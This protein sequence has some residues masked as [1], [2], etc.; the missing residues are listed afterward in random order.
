MASVAVAQTIRRL[1]GLPAELKWPN[2]VLIGGRKVCGILAEMEAEMDEVDFV[3]LGIGINV[4]C[5]I[6]Q[7]RA[8]SLRDELGT[9]VSRKEVLSAVLAEIQRQ[10]GML[11]RE[12]LLGE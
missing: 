7:Q 3:N 8:T 5:S 10:Q 1:F 11:T 9:D 12:D 2:D 6:S 4:N